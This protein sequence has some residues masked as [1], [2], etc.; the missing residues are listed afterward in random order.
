MQDVHDSFWG[1]VDDLRHTLFRTVVIIAMGFV[2]GIECL[3]AYSSIF[4]AAPSE[5]FQAGMVV[6]KV[7]QWQVINTTG[8][9][10][11]VKLP[12][13]AR[14]ISS[15]PVDEQKGGHPHYRLPAGDALIYQQIILSPLLIMGPIDGLV[16]VFK[17]C[18]WL[19]IALT[20]PI[21]GWV[22]LRFILPGMKV[23]ERAVLIPFLL[24]SL[25]CMAAGV[26]LLI[27]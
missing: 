12:S 24:G 3:S 23:Q 11:S 19:S 1:H 25:V 21:W 2:A 5:L 14:V 20:A 9:D 22:W 13:H 6:Q 15:A 27:L 8:I 10:Q 4:D 7:E 16:L 18:F 26:L 17:A